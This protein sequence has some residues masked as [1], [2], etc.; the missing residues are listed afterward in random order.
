RLQATRSEAGH[1]QIEPLPLARRLADQVRRR[2]EPAIECERER[3]HAPVAR[4]AVR[5]AVQGPAARLLR[6]ELVT[7][8]RLLR[9]DEEG[10][11]LGAE[12]HIG[13]G[14]RE[15]RED[16]GASREGTPGFGARDEE[17]RL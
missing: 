14:A 6:L 1:L 3:M 13:I 12:L 15:K 10:E 9:H 5:L 4:R 17:T 2:H 7:A 16:V 8:E 11:S